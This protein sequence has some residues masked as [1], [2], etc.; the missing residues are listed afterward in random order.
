MAAK[1]NSRNC[2]GRPIWLLPQKNTFKKLSRNKQKEFVSCCDKV[3]TCR[4]FSEEKNGRFFLST[5]CRAAWQSAKAFSYRWFWSLI[6]VC[7]PSPLSKYITGKSSQGQLYYSG[8]KWAF[9][10]NSFQRS[11]QPHLSPI[12]KKKRVPNEI[13]YLSIDTLQAV[14]GQMVL[15]PQPCRD[16]HFSE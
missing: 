16:R 12:L 14:V 2:G 6:F 7:I 3:C 1:T 4:T 15:L 13:Y 8:Q 10:S 9:W 11:Q 5:R